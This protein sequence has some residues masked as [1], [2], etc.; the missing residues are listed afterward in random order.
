M[1]KNSRPL[2][3]RPKRSPTTPPASP[4]LQATLDRIANHRQALRTIDESP[5]LLTFWERELDYLRTYGVISGARQVLVVRIQETI[6]R[7][8]EAAGESPAT[9]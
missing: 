9:S 7:L 2:P 4:R 3:R 8:R 6:E 1:S 5:D